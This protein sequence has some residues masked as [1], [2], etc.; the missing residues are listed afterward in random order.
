MKAQLPMADPVTQSRAGG[1]E[2]AA[3][4][5]TV[6]FYGRCFRSVSTEVRHGP[7]TGSPPQQRDSGRASHAGYGEEPRGAA[8]P[9]AQAA[10]RLLTPT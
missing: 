6:A 2:H 8:N 3:P 7:C 4:T 5:G 10:K 9:T 1:W